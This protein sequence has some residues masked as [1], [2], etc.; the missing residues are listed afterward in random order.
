MLDATELHRR[1]VAASNAGRFAE[2]RRRLDLA[3]NRTGDPDLLARIEISLAYVEAETGDVAD[4]LALCDAALR[5]RRI[6]RGTRGIAR[7]QRG[8]LLMRRGQ[9]ERALREL[10]SAAGLVEEPILRARVALN[11]GNI[12]LQ[13]GRVAAARDAFETAV[14]EAADAPEVRAKAQHNLGY[15]RLLAGDLV[16]ALQLMEECAP[17]LA[18]LGPVYQAAISQDRAEILLAAGMVEEGERAL[19]DAVRAYGARRLRQFQAEAELS[20]ARTLLRIDPRRAA[21]V[22]RRSAARF[23]RRGSGTWA[24]RARGLALIAEVSAGGRSARLSH[25]VDRLVPQLRRL[26]LADEAAAVALYGARVSVRRGDLPDAARRL[27]PLRL[28]EYAPVSTRLMRWEVRADLARARG[29]RRR[30]LDDIRAGLAELHTWQAS[31]GSLDLQSTLV[32]HGRQLAVDGLRMAVADGRPEALFEW[33]ERA[34]AL[35]ARVAPVRPVPDPVLSE[36]LAELRLLLAQQPAPRSA[37]ARRVGR[38]RERVRQHAWYGTGEGM[39]VEPATLDDVQRRLARR[40]AAFMSYLTVEDVVWC[41]VVTADSAQVTQVAPLPA[42]LEVS[43]GLAADLDMLAVDLPGSLRDAVAAGLSH[44]MKRL[45]ELVLGPAR[46]LVGDRALVITP[47]ASLAGMP[48]GMLPSLRGRSVVVPQSA[49][50]WVAARDVG[51]PGGRRVGFVAGPHVPRGEEEV[52]LGSASWSAARVLTGEAASTAA[53]TALADDTDVL[54]VSA[55]GHH[56]ADNP[57]F[58][59][60]ELVNG[61][62]FG[63]DID[64]VETPPHTVVLSACELGR[65]SVRGGEELVGMSAAWL[66]AGARTVIASPALVADDTACE[67]LA[68][69]HVELAAGRGPAEALAVAAGTG[70]LRPSPFVC[71]GSGW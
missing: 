35:I 47:T 24:L 44:R 43:G 46:R 52:R 10:T 20:H 6:S 45:D 34:R 71:Y 48:W 12:H 9:W 51:L 14:A 70:D 4:G 53:V 16:A 65:V 7:S 17:V 66:H 18:T 60:I 11:A 22:A 8:L 68:A 33:S 41:L 50:R 57:L 61:L 69:F 25:E 32:R 5:R 27:R 39:V 31:F 40:D 54:H 2:A 1:G 37:D 64:T 21:A 58:S 55:H 23:E 63:Y 38:L 42:V 67:V 30:S 29:A 36:E 49:T 13:R 56:V 26:G 62:W 59:G 28:G 19:A 15:T 3:R